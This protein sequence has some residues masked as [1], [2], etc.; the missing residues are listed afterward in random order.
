ME[1]RIGF[2]Q[3]VDFQISHRNC[4][5]VAKHSSSCGLLGR[6]QMSQ[7][8]GGTSAMISFVTNF[9]SGRKI[10]IISIVSVNVDIVQLEQRY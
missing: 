9:T 10:L 1:E 7:K 2:P 3:E 8:S 5:G 6:M 4:I